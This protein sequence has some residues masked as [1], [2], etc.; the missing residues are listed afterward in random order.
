M[1]VVGNNTGAM[2]DPIQVH[3]G[4]KIVDL[5]TTNGTGWENVFHRLLRRTMTM[6]PKIS[7]E[8]RKDRPVLDLAIVLLPNFEGIAKRWVSCFCELTDN[9]HYSDCVPLL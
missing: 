2:M 1:V 7:P 3:T 6:K 9:D 5:T 4:G 8:S